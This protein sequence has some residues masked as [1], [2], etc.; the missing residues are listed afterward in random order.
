MDRNAGNYLEAPKA[1]T[2]RGVINEVR[3]RQEQA[4]SSAPQ[5]RNR[6]FGGKCTVLKK[7]LVTLLELFGAREIVPLLPPIVKPLITGDKNPRML[8]NYFLENK[9]RWLPA[10]AQASIK[11][12]RNFIGIKG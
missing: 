10:V 11:I 12:L 3:W 2:R 5:F 6:S 8:S 9:T 7:V 1:I 4:T